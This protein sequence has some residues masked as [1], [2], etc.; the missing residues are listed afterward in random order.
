METYTVDFHYMDIDFS[1]IGESTIYLSELFEILG[2]DENAADA[3]KVEFS[4]PE[5]IQIN[6]EENDWLL[7]S[8][9]PFDTEETLTVTMKDG[10]V[11]VI[12]VTDDAAISGTEV[13]GGKT[14]YHSVSILDTWNHP[15]TG[16][17]EWQIGD[18]FSGASGTSK[19]QGNTSGYKVVSDDGLVRLQKNVIPTNVENEF[20][21]Y[22]SVDVMYKTVIDEIINGA[23]LLMSNSNAQG[24]SGGY[25]NPVKKQDDCNNVY[26]GTSGEDN[27]NALF[28][29][30]EQAGTDAYMWTVNMTYQGQTYTIYRWARNNN[31]FSQGTMIIELD[32][33]WYSLALANKG[34]GKTYNVTLTDE[35]IE[36]L[37]RTGVDL[38]GLIAEDTMGSDISISEGTASI[39]SIS[40]GSASCITTEESPYI[41]WQI[42]SLNIKGL[43]NDGDYYTNVA[44]LLYKVTLDVTDPDFVSG[45]WYKVNNQAVLTYKDIDGNT[46]TAEFPVPQIKGTTYSFEFVKEFDPELAASQPVPAATFTLTGTALGENNIS[47][48]TGTPGTTT[49]NGITATV[50][51][52]GKNITFSKLPWGQ[53]TLTE[54]PPEGYTVDPGSPW[55]MSIGYTGNGS[56]QYGQFLSP[57][58]ENVTSAGATYLNTE[59]ATDGVW[60]IINKRNIIEVEKKVIIDK[61][62][63]PDFDEASVDQTIYIALWD[64]TTDDY[65]MGSDGKILVKEINIVDGE[66]VSGLPVT[67]GED[68]DIPNHMYYVSELIKTEDVNPADVSRIKPGDYADDAHEYVYSFANLTFIGTD[69]QGNEAVYQIKTPIGHEWDYDAGGYSHSSGRTADL[70]GASNE[71]RVLFENTYTPETTI[72]FIVQKQWGRRTIAADGTWGMQTLP[73]ASLP[74]DAQ[75]T[76]TLYQNIGTSSWT[77]YATIT[78]NGTAD[79]NGEDI[80][81]RAVFKDLPK[82]DTD[83]TSPTYSL[84]YHYRAKETAKPDG[85]EPFDAVTDHTPMGQHGSDELDYITSTGGII[86]NIEKITEITVKKVDDK[87][88]FLPG[89][90]FKLL[91]PDINNHESL[92]KGFDVTSEQGFTI[93]NLVSGDYK[94]VE[95][96]SPD[97]Y[98][99]LTNTIEFSVNANPDTG[100]NVITW[101]G[102]TAPENVSGDSPSKTTND[103][104]TIT[105]VNTPGAAL[106]NTGGPGTLLYTLSGLMLILGSALMYGFRMRRRERRYN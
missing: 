80:A 24:L 84:P 40:T 88:V 1:I 3:V 34:A 83:E 9:Q 62:L 74:A 60:K 26:Y 10:T 45:T 54:T 87:N 39:V 48:T 98:I 44:E 56:S 57:A 43:P 81:W 95:T 17:N 4:D 12:A 63:D 14:Y 31:E 42:G 82:F 78:L 51:A 73:A 30:P 66:V 36:L 93:G 101:K 41:D 77:E 86:Y 58:K 15:L 55:S 2:V 104:D 53:Y 11:Y 102:G 59:L 67:F 70:S 18:F 16:V 65:L 92:I 97:G 22:L 38:S 76:I 23:A 68:E 90:S 96:K 25:G 5:L 21:V 52:D 32:G 91:G 79:E 19:Y 99:I 72:E 69:S 13:I 85:F 20:Y 37:S 28:P 49:L 71:A 50:G 106:P 8:L 103:G 105:I 35:I 89:A 61:T 33:T 29:T 94:L 7:T 6:Q 27:I 47:V 75:V 100:E 46:K 64:A